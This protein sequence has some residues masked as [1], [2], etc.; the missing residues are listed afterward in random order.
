[1][2]IAKKIMQLLAGASLLVAL[3]ETVSA[4]E[5]TIYNQ[6]HFHY[7]LL[8]PALA[9]AAECT[10]LMATHKQQWN[11]MGGAPYTSTLSFQTRTRSR[12]GVGAYVYNDRNGYSYQQG[13][14]V[15][16]AYHIPL[17]RGNRYTRSKTLDRQ[18]SFA[19][20]AKFYR[21]SLDGEVRDAVLAE[22]GHSIKKAGYYPNANFGVFYQDYHYFLGLSMTNLVP[23]EIDMFGRDEPK[24]PFSAF[25]QAGGTIDLG[26]SSRLEPSAVFKMDAESRKQLDVG[27]RFLSTPEQS[28]ISWWVGVIYKHNL[29]DGGGQSLVL[30]PNATVVFGKWRVGYAFNLDLNRLAGQNYGTHEIMLGYSF[31]H[32]KAFCR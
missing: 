1:M 7:Y 8:N 17:S 31:C 11:G 13:A 22:E 12:V 26:R 24:R 14:Q 15:S 5:Y 32:T 20:S 10:H 2:R 18:L 3:P 28:D 25:I 29:D 9:G 23:V 16:V 4:Q 30:L 21:Y 19:V 27:V 6:Y